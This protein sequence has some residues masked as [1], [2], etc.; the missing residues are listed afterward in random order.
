MQYRKLGR[1]ELKVSA[2]GIGLEHMRGQPRETQFL[3][4]VLW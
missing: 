4:R 3:R 2:I 1:I